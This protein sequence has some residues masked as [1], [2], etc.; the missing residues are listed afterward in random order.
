MSANPYFGEPRISM[1]SNFALEMEAKTSVM[2]TQVVLLSKF[3]LE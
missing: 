2:E 3:Y 1:I